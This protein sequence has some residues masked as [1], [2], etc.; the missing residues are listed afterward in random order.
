[1]A[2]ISFCGVTGKM[3]RGS[4][5]ET[6]AWTSCREKERPA[7][8]GSCFGCPLRLEGFRKHNNEAY[9]WGNI[10]V[11]GWGASTKTRRACGEMV[12]NPGS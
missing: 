12:R 6:S 9:K 2:M 7:A 10:P 5:T 1:M 11:A 3:F 8:T 4:N